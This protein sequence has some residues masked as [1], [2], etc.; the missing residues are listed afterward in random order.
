MPE[1]KL[2]YSFDLSGT[3]SRLEEIGILSDS[4]DYSFERAD[5][6]S[7]SE[8]DISLLL[9][10]TRDDGE[11]DRMVQEA[12]ALASEAL[13]DIPELSSSTESWQEDEPSDSGN[14]EVQWGWDGSGLA[15]GDIVVD[16]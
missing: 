9:E 6:D 11:V 14:S 16:A 12:R 15:T 4:S 10:R 5:S 3:C 7:S 13:E 8:L 2:C 1:K